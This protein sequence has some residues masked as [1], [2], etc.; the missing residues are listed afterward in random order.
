MMISRT[1]LKTENGSHTVETYDQA[2]KLVEQ[3]PDDQ[4]LKTW[5]QVTIF[6][7]AK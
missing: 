7:E 4:T 6:Y 2:K 5:V 3:N 1:V